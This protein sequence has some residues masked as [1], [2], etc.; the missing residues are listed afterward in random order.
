MFRKPR[1]PRTGAPPPERQIAR[2]R[3]PALADRL[4]QIGLDAPAPEDVFEPALAA[5][6][7]ASGARA[8]ALCLFDPR[9]GVLRLTAECGLSDEGCRRLRTV[10]R[11]DPTAWDMPLHGL[12]NRRAYL[13]ESAARNRY[14]PRLVENVGTVRTVACVPVYAGT[15]PVASLVLVA[16]APRSFGER[17][18]HA[19]EAGLGELARLV[20]ATRRRAAG[21]EPEPALPATVPGIVTTAEAAALAAERDRLVAEL[22]ARAAEREEIAA[23][24][25][26]RTAETER[27]GA[28][29][30]AAVGERT[31]LARELA[32]ARRAVENLNAVT[33]ALAGAEE[34]RARLAAALEASAAERSEQAKALAA[35]D[36]VRV[37]AEQTTVVARMEL[38]AIQRALTEKDAAAAAR[39]AEETAQREQTRARL[40]EIES[41]LAREREAAR[42]AAREHER[43]AST[44]RDA[45]A[46]ERR[47][48]EE[49]DALAAEGASADRADAAR[50]AAEAA[51]ARDAAEAARAEATTGTHVIEALEEEAE[52]AHAEIARLT[53][54]L[55]RARAAEAPVADAVADLRRR[56]Q[57]ASAR[58]VDHERDVARL[59]GELETAIAS[60]RAGEAERAALAAHVETLAAERDRSREDYAAVAA[61]RDRLAAAVESAEQ[62]RREQAEVLARE[63]AERQR[64]AAALAHAETAR[65]ALETAEARREA[66]V[67]AR[68][69]ELQQEIDRLRAAGATPIEEIPIETTDLGLELETDTDTDPASDEETAPERPAMRVVSVGTPAP[70]PIVP[71]V[72]AAETGGVAVVDVADG[73]DEGVVV[74]PPDREIAARLV[75]LAPERII[76]NLAAPGALAGLAGVRAAGCNARLFACI[77]ATGADRGLPLCSFEPSAPPLEP[78]AI[79]AAI[80]GTGDRGTRVVTAGVDVDA[81]MSLRQ[82]LA[83]RGMSVSMAWDAKQATDLLGVVRPEVVVVDLDLPRRDGYAIVARL[84]SVDPAPHAVLVGGGDD[85]AAAFAATL[86]D[87]AFATALQSLPALVG[88]LRARREPTPQVEQR[89]PKL[90]ALGLTRK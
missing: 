3:P 23:E 25:S 16:V 40:A 70:R 62:A 33:T 14:V 7:E 81:L 36:Q 88:T 43:L 45:A 12:V 80:G 24:L 54:A 61:E 83:R 27:L 18:V 84:A 53:A 39:I 6:L 63:S 75:E 68:I 72:A 22:A 89:K 29:L 15:L 67:A 73:W 57:E 31:R 47:L 66:D 17:D 28:S 60:A 78:E 90:R 56:E 79:I 71:R 59:R 37:N 86:A 9:H 32:E 41:T 10:R 19:L 52:Q 58:A 87:P 76:V 69:D 4:R 2:P 48:R 38:A 13:I 11:G 44:L 1:R 77:A 49:R 34:A 82:A 51:A 74:V 30:D 35:L 26:A 85:A 46:H 50:A 42:A 65:A 55:E 21:A 5:F 8:G 64:L 20:E